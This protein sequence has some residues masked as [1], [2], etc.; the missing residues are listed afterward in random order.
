MA[1]N[2]P[3]TST[4]DDSGLNKAQK[5][6][7][8]LG[9]PAGKLGNILKASVVPGLVAAAG[10]VLVFTKGLL[11]AIQAASDPQAKLKLFLVTLVGLLPIL[12]R[13]LHGI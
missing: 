8:G 13:P 7:A 3:I 4:F 6:L 10:S 12:L 5:A 9:G 11:P 2:L 1:I